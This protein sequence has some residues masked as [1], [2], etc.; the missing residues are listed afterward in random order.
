MSCCLAGWIGIPSLGMERN[1]ATTSAVSEEV[2]IRCLSLSTD[3]ISPPEYSRDWLKININ[4]IKRRTERKREEGQRRER[5]QS[6]IRKE[7]S[8]ILTDRAWTAS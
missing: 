4:W 3:F 1:R 2:L 8:G 5:Q 7:G 6:P